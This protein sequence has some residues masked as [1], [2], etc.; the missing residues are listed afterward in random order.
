MTLPRVENNPLITHKEGGL[1]LLTN[2]LCNATS[3]PQFIKLFPSGSF[4]LLI[5]LSSPHVLTLINN[6]K[7]PNTLIKS[8][9]L[10]SILIFG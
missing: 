7:H 5:L 4:K 10:I 8:L 3:S 2:K 1:V 6:Y 9:F